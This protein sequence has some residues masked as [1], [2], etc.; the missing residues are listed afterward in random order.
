MTKRELLEFLRDRYDV[1][2]EMRTNGHI[3]RNHID[4]RIAELGQTIE[5]IRSRKLSP[6]PQSKTAR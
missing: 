6:A 2:C 3:D 1:L 5:Y 4:G